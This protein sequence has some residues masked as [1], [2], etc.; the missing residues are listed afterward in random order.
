MTDLEFDVR[1]L[2]RRKVPFWVEFV[3]N[4]VKLCSYNTYAQDD[5]AVTLYSY[6][7]IMQYNIPSIASQE[8]K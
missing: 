5:I 8:V 6:D 3:S 1:L 4:G 2:E 7:G